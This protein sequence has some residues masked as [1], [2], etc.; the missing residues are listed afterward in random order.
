MRVTGRPRQATTRSARRTG[1]L[2][3]AA[4]L[5]GLLAAVSIPMLIG[6]EPTDRGSYPVPGLGLR[7]RE[8]LAAG[9]NSLDLAT[10]ML[11]TET[12]TTRYPYGDGKQGD[13]A[14]FGVFKQNW[15]MIR[16]SWPA[17]RDATSGDYARGAA[18]NDDLR[19]DV[20]V[21][22]AAQQRWPMEIWFGGHRNGQ[23]GLQQPAS[24]DVVRYRDAV[25][26]IRDRIDADPAHLSDDTRFWVHVPAI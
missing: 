22:H 9:G 20:A 16:R 6:D 21:L 4:C 25:Y 24:P 19:L 14:N 2:L 3:I 13:A 23:T 17:F 11:E 10:A 26:W 5:T 15:F 18:L 7:K 1:L 8:L 12:M